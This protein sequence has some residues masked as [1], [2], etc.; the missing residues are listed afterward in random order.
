M[1]FLIVL[2]VVLITAAFV[3][4]VYMYCQD[5]RNKTSQEVPESFKIR[6]NA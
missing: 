6:P 2:F 1:I 5:K 3:L 4:S